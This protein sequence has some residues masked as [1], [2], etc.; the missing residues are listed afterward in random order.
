MQSLRLRLLTAVLW[1]WCTTDGRSQVL[2]TEFLAS[3]GAGLLDE[4]G[5]SSDWIEI[6]NAGFVTVDLDGYHLTDKATEMEKWI[7]PQRLLNPGAY[8]VVFASGKDR[9]TGPLHTNFALSASG[10]YLALS[11]ATGNVLSAFDPK[12]PAQTADI[13][14]GL[15]Q[16]VAEAARAYFTQPSPGAVNP[17]NVTLINPPVIWPTSGTFSTAQIVN[18]SAPA[19]VEIRYT[20]DGSLPWSGSPLYTTALNLNSSARLRVRA[21]GNGQAISPVAGE[22]YLKLSADMSA[23]SSNLPIMILDNFQAQRPTNGSLAEW[24]IFEP[25]ASNQRSSP[26]AIPQLTSRSFIKVHGSSTASDP[27]YSLTLEARNQLDEDRQVRPLGLPQAAD[28]VLSAPYYF[29]RTLLHN[30]FAYELERSLGRYGVRTRQV[31]VYLNT[32]GG[33]VSQAD[34]YGVYTFCEKVETGADRVN[35]HKLSATDNALPE[36]SGGYLLKIDR[37][38]PGDVGLATLGGRVYYFVDPKESEISVLQ[39]QWIGSYLD[40]FWTALND[41]NFRDPVN[42]YARYLDLPAAVDHHILNVALKNVDALRLSTYLSKERG[43]KL[44]FGPCWDFD[45]ALESLDSRDDHWDTW[46]GETGDLGTDFFREGIWNQLFRDRSFWQRWV[47]RYENLRQGVLSNTQLT[48]QLN[49]QSAQL[50]EA[51]VRN[52][53]KWTAVPPRTSWNWEVQ[54]LKDWLTA[55]LDWMDNQFTRPPTSNAPTPTGGTVGAGFQLTLTSP[56]LARP[57]VKIYYTLDGSDPRATAYQP[58]ATTVLVASNAPARGLLPTVDIGTAW[59]GNPAGPDTFDDSPWIS[60]TNGIG[61]DDK[62]DYDPYIGIHF[63]APNPVMKNVMTSAYQRIQFSMTAA[64]LTSLQKLE[65]RVHFDDGFAAFLNGVQIAS[66]NVPSG[67]LTWDAASSTGQYDTEAMQWA[68]YDVSSWKPLLRAGTNTLALHGLNT[69]VSSTDFLVQAELLAG[70]VPTEMSPQA[71]L[72]TGPIPVP[73]IAS[74][75][76]RTFDPAPVSQPYPYAPSGG[77]QTPTGTPWSAPLKLFLYNQT[78]LPSAQ[79]LIIS[80]IMYHPSEPTPDERAMGWQQLEE[81][82]YLI[83]R[84]VGTTILSLAGM[85]LSEGIS[86]NVENVPASLLT[87]GASIAIVKN[88]AA[89]L[90]RYG[91]GI[92]ILGQF[93]GDLSKEGERLILRSANGTILHFI[94]YDDTAPWPRDADGLGYSLVVA[95]PFDHLSLMNASTWRRSL[96]PTGENVRGASALSLTAWQSLYFGND[97]TEAA[98]TADPDLDGLTNLV[99]YAIGTNPH[100]PSQP[101]LRVCPQAGSICVEYDRRPGLT[102]LTV[103]PME[104]PQLSGWQPILQA[105]PPVPNASGTE[106]LKVL[107]PISSG[108]KFILLKISSP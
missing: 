87:A 40:E 6:Y 108:Q 82:Q 42:G 13:S 75:F 67:G 65:L 69:P 66:A 92:P 80:E 22:T 25:V 15:V 5:D 24:M 103:T 32:D 105:G 34:Y 73:Q 35:I 60:G 14:Y 39:R 78:P 26:A 74:V 20:L 21:F 52:F 97:A 55:R 83:L 98:L 81:F 51:Q 89:F 107:M 91:S 3:N 76:A 33:P 47:D 56:S 41:V 7:F 12:F 10:E 8:L 16:P 46:R 45:R 104:S 29:D 1:L 50:A 59:R 36:I 53:A 48:N 100:Q 43:G 99:E 27:Q 17:T 28:W 63:E 31:E 70:P 90:Y 95:R 44:Q 2:I 9:L 38:D 88:S 85:S 64:Q 68:I 49:A 96:D 101:P 79:S 102:D 86:F 54:H 77:S 61:Y 37:A 19:G 84:N 71:I 11:D 94:E 62:T 57:G 30:A 93:S 106:T 58:S 18:I 72:Y 23:V 4:D